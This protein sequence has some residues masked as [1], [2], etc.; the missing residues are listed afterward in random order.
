MPGVDGKSARPLDFGIP[1]GLA[2]RRLVVVSS[3]IP[4]TSTIIVRLEMSQ[5][6]TETHVTELWRRGG[7]SFQDVGIP[8]CATRRAIDGN[9]SGLLGRHTSSDSGK[10]SIREAHKPT[11]LDSGKHVHHP[12]FRRACCPPAA[13]SR[14]VLKVD[15]RGRSSIG[16][17]DSR[18]SGILDVGCR[19]FLD[20]ENVRW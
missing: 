11:I 16:F 19:I 13:D 17:W 14:S 18:R 9:D 20:S 2:S 3:W 12:G 7:M 4:K 5:V 15:E 6:R 10:F 8:G 1:G